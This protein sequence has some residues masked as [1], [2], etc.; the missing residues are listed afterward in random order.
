MPP[1][2]KLDLHLLIC[3]DCADDVELVVRELQRAGINPRGQSVDSEPQYASALDS[4]DVPQVILADYNMP[5]FNALWRLNCC[6]SGVWIFRSSSSPARS[7][8]KRR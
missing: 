8:K 2:S 6:A 5:E 1:D 4:D 7:A 3:E